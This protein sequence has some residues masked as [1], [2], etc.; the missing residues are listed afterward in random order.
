MSQVKP[1]IVRH[2]QSLAAAAGWDR[3]HWT[4]T[5]EFEDGRLRRWG[6]EDPRNSPGELGA[7]DAG[8]RLAMP[9]LMGRMGRSPGGREAVCQDGDGASTGQ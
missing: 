9:F 4:I 7:Y 2:L 1:L 8:F 5:L 6:Q 3:G